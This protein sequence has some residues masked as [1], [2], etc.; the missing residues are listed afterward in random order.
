MSNDLKIYNFIYSEEMLNDTDP[1][2]LS[3]IWIIIDVYIYIN[4]FSYFISALFI[5]YRFE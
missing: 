2:R 1:W 5:H 3:V 4:I